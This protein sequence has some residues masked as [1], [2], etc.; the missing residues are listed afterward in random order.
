MHRKTLIMSRTFMA[1]MWHCLPSVFVDQAGA[2]L[3]EGYRG[4]ELGLEFRVM[5][6]FPV[7][8][9]TSPVSYAIP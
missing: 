6:F 9:I 1:F 4:L 7:I 2:D 8:F 3:E 5:V